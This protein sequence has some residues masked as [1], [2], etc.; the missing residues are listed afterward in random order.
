MTS[1][2]KSNEGGGCAVIFGVLIVLALVFWAISAVGHL[3][4]LTPTYSEATDRPDGWVSR[5]YE[6]V[7]LGYILTLLFIVVVAALIWLGIRALSEVEADAQS[8]RA[9]LSQVGWV[10]GGLLVAI[11]V[12]PVGKRDDAEGNVPRVVGMNAGQAETALDKASLGASFRETPIDD[13]RCKVVEQEPRPGAELDEF[14]DVKLR[15]KG[16]VPNVV[17][18]KAPDAETKLMEAGFESRYINEPSDFDTTRCRVSRQKPSASAAPNAKIALR[19][20]CRKPRPEPKPV[21]EE[22]V[23]P[24][25]AED[26]DPNYEPCVPPFPPDVDCDDVNGPVTVTGDDPHGLDR[27]GDG[28]ACE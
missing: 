8:A 5:H 4:D 28:S 17:G 19:L 7:V 18:R 21:P 13:E 15:C 2:S 11:L 3:L 9:R 10:A 24:A 23:E 27:D 14:S 25:P 22:P 1:K 12:L 6:G 16:D 20:K 26:C